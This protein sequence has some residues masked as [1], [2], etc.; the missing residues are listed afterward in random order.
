MQKFMTGR[1]GADN[2]YKGLLWIYLVLI[3]LNMIFGRLIGTKFYN[4]VSLLSL[5]IVVYA[6]YRFFSK[7][8]EKRRAENQKWLVFENYVKKQ[9][10]LLNN[11]WTFR[12]THIFRHCPNCK[13]VLKLKRQKGKHTVICPHCSTKFNVNVH[14]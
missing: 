9:F 4:I 2:L 8:I 10:R 3:I 1:Y 6:F 5:L 11:R 14:F 12:K 13:C 7:N